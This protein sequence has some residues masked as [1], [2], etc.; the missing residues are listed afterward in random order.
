MEESNGEFIKRIMEEL[1]PV[2]AKSKY[3]ICF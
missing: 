3:E 2:E 1:D